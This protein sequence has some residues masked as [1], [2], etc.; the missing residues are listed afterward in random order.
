MHNISITIVVRA[1][2]GA[3]SFSMLEPHQNDAVRIQLGLDPYPQAYIKK[4]LKMR[5]RFQLGLQKTK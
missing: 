3:A 2:A 5:L 4:N 1:R